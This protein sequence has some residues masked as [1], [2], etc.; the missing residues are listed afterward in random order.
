MHL[1]G[2]AG[3]SGL[4]VQPLKHGEFKSKGNKTLSCQGKGNTKSLTSKIIFAFFS[5]SCIEKHYQAVASVT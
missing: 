2:E 4:Q 5:P 1:G 3:V